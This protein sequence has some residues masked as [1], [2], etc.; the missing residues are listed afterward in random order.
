MVASPSVKVSSSMRS[1]GQVSGSSDRAFAS[2]AST[3]AIGAPHAAWWYAECATA[4]GS[5][6]RVGDDLERGLGHR[7]RRRI[8]PEPQA[9]RPV[10]RYR[11][12]EIL[13]AHKVG[14]GRPEL[15][16]RGRH[17]LG[18]RQ[19]A[20][21]PERIGVVQQCWGALGLGDQRELP[22]EEPGGIAERAPVR[23]LAAGTVECCRRVCRWDEATAALGVLGERRGR[24]RFQRQPVE[25][26][27]VEHEAPTG[28]RRVAYR[29]AERGVHKRRA[30]GGLLEEAELDEAVDAVEHRRDIELGEQVDEHVD[31]DRF[32]EQRR[33]ARDL[34]GD[35][36]GARQAPRCD[37]AGRLGHLG[38]V[39]I[40]RPAIGAGRDDDVLHEERHPAGHLEDASSLVRRRGGVCRR[41]L[42]TA[43]QHLDVR[44]LQRPEGQPRRPDPRDV[45]RERDGRCPHPDLARPPGDDRG[46]GLAER[47]VQDV[48]QQ[49]RGPLVGPVRVVE[50]RTTGRSD[51]A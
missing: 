37:R 8:R 20:R 17:V 9:D 2:A 48:Q 23:S 32:G 12:G 35:I 47:L 6:G 21:P 42:M 41:S 7:D 15:G 44:L 16:D 26:V 24:P 29:S 27:G 38:D 14:L 1:S 19:L 46:H 4:T 45:R 30:G 31:G 25:G 33:G 28:A 36:A 50:R 10:E 40:E 5:G 39:G 13:V 3:T 18:R 11:T 51:A 49:A 43:E 22:L 34:R